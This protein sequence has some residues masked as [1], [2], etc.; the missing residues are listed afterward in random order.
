MSTLPDAARDSLIRHGILDELQSQAGIEWNE[1]EHRIVIPVGDEE[2][3]VGV[4]DYDRPEFASPQLFPDE[5]VKRNADLYLCFDPRHVLCLQ[6][7]GINAC[8][9]TSHDYSKLA[10]HLPTSLRITALITRTEVEHVEDIREAC[11]QRTNHFFV[12]RMPGGCTISQFLDGHEDAAN[13]LLAFKALMAEHEDTPEITGIGHQ[14]GSIVERGGQLLDDRKNIVVAQWNGVCV[15]FGTT[16]TKTPKGMVIRESYSTYE[17]RHSMGGTMR[18]TITGSQRVGEAL[19]MA[20]GFDTKWAIDN[21][22]SEPVRTYLDLTSNDAKKIDHHPWRFGWDLDKRRFITRSSVVGSD[23]VKPNMAVTADPLTPALHNIDLPLGLDWRE[24]AAV[25]AVWGY[26]AHSHAPTAILPMIAT[27]LMALGRRLLCPKAQRY[28]L[29]ASGVTGSGKTSRARLVQC[30]F[31]DFP[32]DQSILTWDATPRSIEATLASAGDCMVLV[33]DLKMSTRKGSEGQAIMRVLMAQGQGIGRM[34]FGEGGHVELEGDMNSM[35]MVTCESFVVK[36]AAI[37]ARG[38]HIEVPN[39][40][41]FDSPESDAWMATVERQ[42]DLPYYAVSFIQFCLNNSEMFTAVYKKAS[43]QV[44]RALERFNPRW[45]HIPNIARLRDRSSTMTAFFQFGLLHAIEQGHDKEDLR[46]FRDAW[47]QVLDNVIEL[48]GGRMLTALPDI[49]VDAW[50]AAI[51][52][53]VG[54]RGG[55]IRFIENGETVGY[56]PEKKRSEAAVVI[57]LTRDEQRSRWEPYVLPY[58]TGFASMAINQNVV[59]ATKRA[60]WSRIKKVVTEMECGEKGGFYRTTRKRGIVLSEDVFRSFL[61]I[62]GYTLDD[63]IDEVV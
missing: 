35:T 2:C 32:D 26:L 29:Y 41:K 5:V 11:K 23:Y 31:G 52:D 34:K 36:D 58:K 49:S 10:E 13:R 45:K 54:V 8:C 53:Y 47:E 17:L 9:V 55:C 15:Q 43:E 21:R 4:E 56:W 25:E 22:Y 46:G 61:A 30:L 40:E 60:N 63:L 42:K 62:L 48:N 1:D 14:V 39:I 50:I 27:A 24:D 33:D 59:K 7:I 3:W 6:E 28:I 51:A 16:L 38:I 18:F 57:E 44:E 12:V 19:R 20:K 37:A